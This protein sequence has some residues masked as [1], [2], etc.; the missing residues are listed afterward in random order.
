MRVREQE[1]S[2][3]EKLLAR[4]REQVKAEIIV[5]A[6]AEESDLEAL[7]AEKRAILQEEQRLKAMLELEKAKLHRKADMQA[8]VR[9]ER[10]RS[11]AKKEYRRDKYSALQK[12]RLE[13]VRQQNM[14]AQGL[15]TDPKTG[16][17][18]RVESEEGW[19]ALQELVRAGTLPARYRPY[20][21]A[22]AGAAPG[23][24]VLEARAVAD[25]ERRRAEEG[26]GRSQAPLASGE[27]G[28]G[29]M[30]STM[31]MMQGG[32]MM[33]VGDSVLDGAGGDG[34]GGGMVLAGT[35]PGIRSQQGMRDGG[36]GDAIDAMMGGGGNDA[37]DAK[38]EEE[39]EED[40]E[41]AYDD[42]E[43]EDDY[44]DDHEP[45]YHGGD[46]AAGGLS[47]VD[48]EPSHEDVTAALSRLQAAN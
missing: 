15:I 42:E 11:R 45:D 28:A 30:D 26:G 8:A 47:A 43:D 21:E 33:M 14:F 6:L 12:Q 20:L 27:L 5:K 2:R 46:A 7:R 36:V 23:M 17:A 44:E 35:V 37:D 25:A 31:S 38:M 1:Q 41:D 32:S 3:R 4:R 13:T 22:G 18:V 29:G 10:Q 16:Y 9:A 19:F 48:A 34:G 24:A 39:E 40:D